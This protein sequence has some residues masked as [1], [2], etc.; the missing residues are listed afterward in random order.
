MSDARIV[1]D[2]IDT[3]VSEGETILDAAQKRGIEIPTLCHAKELLPQG[4]CRICVVEVQGMKSLVGA[5]HTPAKE[6][7]VVQT[8]SPKVLATRQITV[9]LLLASHTGDCVEDTNAKN[10]ALHKLASDLEVGPPRFRVRRPRDYPLEDVSPYVHRDLSKCILCRK[11][12]GACREIAGKELFSV[13][14]RS[15]RSKIVFGLDE[16]I[17]TEVC[18]DCGLC[19]DHCPTGALSSPAAI[20]DTRE[21]DGSV[22]PREADRRDLLNLL[23]DA[24][25]EAGHISADSMAAIADRLSIPVNDA[26]GVAT[27]YS[28]LPTEARGR[29]VVRICKNLPCHM[30]DAAIV[31]GTVRKMLGIGPGDTTG[32]GR[33]SFELTNCIG[34]CDLAPAMLVNDDLHGNL[35]PDKVRGVLEGYE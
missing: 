3:D 28:F 5:C 18:R 17:D 9:E 2:G 26:Y 13:G 25:K 16:V 23:K 32:D 30:K 15:A 33:F 27:F 8:G 4:A 22:P 35:T 19:I 29:H 31:I 11:C 14:Y 20:A 7:M 24:A 1:I 6:G 12:I 10:C 21:G 34:A